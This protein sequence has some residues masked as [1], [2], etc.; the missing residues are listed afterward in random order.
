MGA[1]ATNTSV[2]ITYMAYVLSSPAINYTGAG[3]IITA[4]SVNITTV[5]YILSSPA[6]NYT[7]VAPIITVSS[8]NVTTM[9]Y[10]ATTSPVNITSIIYMYAEPTAQPAGIYYTLSNANV[11]ATY[12]QSIYYSM[13]SVAVTYGT[14][15]NFIGFVTY[16]QPAVTLS[17]NVSAT[18]TLFY[19][20]L[21][22]AGYTLTMGTTGRPSVIVTY[23]IQMS[24]GA[25][26]QQ[27]TGAR[28]AGSNA[29]GGGLVIS[30]VTGVLDGL[31]IAV[32]AS[33][34]E[35]V[36]A[37]LLIGNGGPGSSGYLIVIEG[38][39]YT[40]STGG[41]GG[42]S[43]NCSS[44]PSGAGGGGGYYGGPGGSSAGYAGGPGGSVASTL[45]Y[46]TRWSYVYMML[47]F[48][49]DEWQRYVLNKSLPTY[50]GATYL[51]GYGAGGGGGGIN[52]S[53][54]AGGGGGGMGGQV[55]IYMHN[56]YVP[57]SNQII[58]MG[59]TGGGVTGCGTGGGGGAGGLVYILTHN[60]VAFSGTINVLGGVGSTGVNDSAGGSGAPNTYAIFI[61]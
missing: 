30:A 52:Q 56:L 23:S 49:G 3:M 25:I 5:A 32:G 16:N 59:G 13:A 2:N 57:T 33:G 4:P 19:S 31:I 9:V 28:G 38:I 37:D 10:I 1:V 26:V 34:V 29:G 61:V 47:R 22:L 58:A 55:V 51:A 43:T 39:V 15:N 40:A 60:L 6:I 18:W 48:L 50:I 42:S 27:P 21:N 12:A 45:N 35:G 36:P 24:G 46:P 20:S 11:S 54:S 44:G 17:A 8:I 41:P 14:E 53:H 7:N